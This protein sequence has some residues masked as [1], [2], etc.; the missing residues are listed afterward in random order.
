MKNPT[1]PIDPLEQLID[2][3]LREHPSRRAPADLESRVLAAIERREARSWWLKDFARWPLVARA[4]FIVLCV[5]LGKFA[6]EASTWLIADIDPTGIAAGLGSLLVWMKML[7]IAA[8]SIVRTIPTAWVYAGAMIVGA[9]Y[10]L[11]FGLSTVAYRTL[12]ANR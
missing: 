2:K 12:Y 3:T 8:T 10:A 1:P 9:M 4:V 7:I 6:V 5:A 11:L